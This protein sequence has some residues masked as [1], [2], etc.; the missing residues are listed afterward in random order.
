[1]ND[2]HPAEQYRAVMAELDAPPP[3]DPPPPPPAPRP[4]FVPPPPVPERTD[5]WAILRGLA[6]V[7]M[8][9]LI[10]GLL[11]VLYLKTH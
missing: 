8:F 1:M 5:W 11:A 6:P 9:L 4:V 10:A 2:D 3:P 7:L